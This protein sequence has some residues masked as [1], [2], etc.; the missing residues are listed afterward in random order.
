M[1]ISKVWYVDVRVDPQTGNPLN[2]YTENLRV[3]ADNHDEMV[4]K[5]KQ[6]YN[7]NSKTV[8]DDIVSAKVDGTWV[9]V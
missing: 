8:F 1:K 3:V 5:T 9:V 6:F 2:R 4:S 7:E